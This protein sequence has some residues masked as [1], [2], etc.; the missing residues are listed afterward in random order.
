MPRSTP[1][2]L[3][4]LA[5]D[6]ASRRPLHRQIYD[7]YRE[8]ILDRRL[9]PGQRLPSTRA[10]AGE[11]GVSRL[12]VLEAFAQLLAEGYC[13]SRAG[14]GTFVARS[15]PEDPPPAG[16]RGARPRPGRRPRSRGPASRIP[17]GGPWLAGTGPFV[18]GETAV[19]LFPYPVW[20][21]LVARHGRERDAKYFHYG[22]TMGYRP[23]REAIAAYLRAARGVRCEAE[24]VMV[25]SG[26]QQA[27]ELAARVLL[28]PGDPV[29]IEEP[30]YWGARDA[31]RNQ[32]ARLVPVPVDEEGLDV[33]AGIARAPRARAVYVTP[34]HQFPLGVTMSASRRLQLLDWARRAGA[35]VLEDD[36]NSEYRYESQ[37]VAALQ[38]LDRDARVFYVGTFSKVLFPAL[39]VGYLVVPGDLVTAMART[40]WAMDIAQPTLIQGVLA[41]FLAEGHF[42]RH[43]RRTR[44]LYRERRGVLVE[45]IRAEL[46][47]E[48][49]VHGDQAGMHVLAGLR[50][51]R[52]DRALVERAA[53]AGLKT[54]PLSSAYLGRATRQGL[55]LG[56]GG[57]PA[58]ELPAA[59]ARLRSVL[60]AG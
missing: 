11:L 43:L 44:L 26:S 42:A 51:G 35:W 18:I 52:R 38:G 32:G 46:G 7:G 23:L 37:P 28:D 55:I 39:R 27:L 24:Q 48:L 22:E 56:Y 25:V 45:A 6:R 2:I 58:S 10:L 34:S 21:S 50:A 33:A 4:V 47:D 36:Y 17:A 9:R 40:R 20:A 53:A 16:A 15:L 12:P 19:D 49:A 59:V 41:D 8:A 60:R 29:W 14:S 30:G 57:T 5:V 31:L 13:E 1:A 3:P 54:M